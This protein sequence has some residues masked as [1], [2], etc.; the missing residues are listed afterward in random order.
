MVQCL[1]TVTRHSIS[2]GSRTTS[3]CVNLDHQKHRTSL[4]GLHLFTP[5][6]LSE[7]SSKWM[8]WMDGWYVY[9][10][11]CVCNIIQNGGLETKCSWRRVKN[12]A[13]LYRVSSAGCVL[14]CLMESQCVHPG[15]FASRKCCS[16]NSDWPPLFQ[17]CTQVSS[18]SSTM[19]HCTPWAWLDWQV[20]RY[21]GRQHPG[22]QQSPAQGSVAW[23]LPPHLKKNLA[24]CKQVPGLLAWDLP[25]VLNGQGVMKKCV[26]MSVHQCVTAEWTLFSHVLLP[27]KP[28][29]YQQFTNCM[30][31]LKYNNSS[32]QHSAG[33]VDQPCIS[34]NYYISI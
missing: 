18:P 26:C 7:L 22:T 29:F 25:D 5:L 24:G 23:D 6:V 10:C 11:V 1:Y 13:V 3:I 21:H 19:F 9:V 28:L 15:F 12:Q 20:G 30:L 32:T 2:R 27:G 14:Q 16:V 34:I 17:L 8:E 33:R 4:N 31:Y